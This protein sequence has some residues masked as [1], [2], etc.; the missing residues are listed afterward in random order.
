VLKT[1]ICVTR[2]Q[3]VNVIFSNKCHQRLRDWS[4]FDDV[5]LCLAGF[6]NFNHGL[7]I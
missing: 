2:P 7:L 5:L 6:R 3:N 1:Q 4:Q